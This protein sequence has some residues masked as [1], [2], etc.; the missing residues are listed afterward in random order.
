MVLTAAGA[1]AD[2]RFVIADDAD[3]VLYSAYL[4]ELADVSASYDA[5]D[6]TLTLA[7]PDG[8]I[9]AEQVV[10][11]EEHVLATLSGRAL[12]G[13]A[14]R[15]PFAE[16]LSERAGRPLRLFHVEVGQASPQPLTVLGDG[17][18]RRLADQ[19]GLAELDTR[20]FK[21]SIEL[22]P[23][24]PHA[25]DDWDGT[26]LRV[27]DVVLRVCGQVPR[28]VLITRDPETRERDHDALRAILAYREAMATGA[29]PFGMYAA[30][31][32][33]GVIHVGDEISLLDREP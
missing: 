21:M 11:G 33:P 3:R 18:V 16:V 12:P 28:C 5:G 6:G 15:G 27:G 4:D 10:L 13:C 23:L 24:A 2:R 9:A 8:E 26:F 31:V 14:V 25:E 20:R 30:V 22:A 32:E 1:V 17:S 7:G 19:L 29:A